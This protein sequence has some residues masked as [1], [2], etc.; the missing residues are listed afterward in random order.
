MMNCCSM[1][2]KSFEEHRERGAQVTDVLFAVR[3]RSNNAVHLQEVGVAQCVGI[4][5]ARNLTVTPDGLGNRAAV[6]HRARIGVGIS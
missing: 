1:I 6:V 2:N 5:V 3:S 4:W